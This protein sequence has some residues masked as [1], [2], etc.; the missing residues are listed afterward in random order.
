MAEPKYPKH[1]REWR[2]TTGMDNARFDK[3]LELFEAAYRAEYGRRI[4]ERVADTPSD[5]TFRTYKALLFFTLF[6]L[7]AG[8]TYDVLGYVFHLDGSNAKRNQTIGLT[9]LKRALCAGNYLP[10]RE[11]ASVEEFAAYFEPHKVVLLD[12]TE[13]R[14]QRPGEDDMQQT[15][16]SGKKKP[17]R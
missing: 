8:L 10:K 15:C 9:V 4:E 7:K 1:D 5:M 16:Y 2:A 14:I 6:S 12:G 3:L 11:F 13:Q 17:H